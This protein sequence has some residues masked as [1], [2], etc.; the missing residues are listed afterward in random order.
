M[1]TAVTAV[2]VA[3]FLFWPVTPP[4][5]AEIRAEEPKISTAVECVMALLVLGVGAVAV[6]QLIKLCRK[7]PP[8]PA[9]D[10]PPPPTNSVPTNGLPILTNR[11]GRRVIV[12]RA[13]TWGQSVVLQTSAGLGPWTNLCRF[14]FTLPGDGTLIAVA[15][16]DGVP[17][18]TN[19]APLSF[20]TNSDP[21]AILDFSALELT[22]G[23]QFYRLAAP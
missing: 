15:S 9:P 11:P 1:K 12:P 10:P 19:Q 20:V 16:K 8:L 4:P 5:R 14:D 17:L 3:A 18:W 2:L 13:S 22:N 23:G 7:L 6:Y 21:T